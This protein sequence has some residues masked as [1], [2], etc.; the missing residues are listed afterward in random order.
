MAPGE[1]SFPRCGDVKIHD[2]CLS[3]LH[4]FSDVDFFKELFDHFPVS[5]HPVHGLLH[6]GILMAR[7]SGAYSNG[8]NAPGDETLNVEAE[9]LFATERLL[10][11]KHVSNAYIAVEKAGIKN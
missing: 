9:R 2:K 1:T 3:V 8:G 7:G 6:G 4:T 11:R 5:P 10:H